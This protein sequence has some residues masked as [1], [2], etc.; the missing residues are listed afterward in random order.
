[1]IGA[2]CQRAKGVSWSSATSSADTSGAGARALTGGV[3]VPGH[4]RFERHR[5]ERHRFERHRFERH[6]TPA[7][8]NAA[9]LEAGESR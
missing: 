7:A 1:M 4:H 2:E 3:M 8:L 5:F 6:R 9:A